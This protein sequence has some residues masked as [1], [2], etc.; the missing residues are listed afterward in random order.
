[1]R[2]LVIAAILMVGAP[3]GAQTVPN[4]EFRGWVA[5]AQ[6]S[7]EQTKGCA[8]DGPDIL[9]CVEGYVPVGGASSFVMATLYKAQL[10]RVFV[11]S[12]QGNWPAISAAFTAKYGKPCRQEV[13][14]WQSAGGVKLKNIVEHWCFATGELSLRQYGSKLTETLAIYQDKNDTPPK[15]GKVDF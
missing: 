10:S 13:E 2:M 4:F 3:A 9:S 12:K 15:P 14:D 5:G 11:S 7:P 8:S 1:M 6:P